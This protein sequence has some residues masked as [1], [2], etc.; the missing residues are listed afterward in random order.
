MSEQLFDIC[1]LEKIC[2]THKAHLST[3]A[4][5]ITDNGTQHRFVTL[6]LFRVG[7][8]TALRQFDDCISAIEQ[9]GYKV[10]TKQREYAVYDS[11][12]LLDVGWI[13]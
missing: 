5:K 6:R 2:Q 9:A 3:N 11:N 7:K 1:P 13:N 4:F 10:V 12:V 8:N